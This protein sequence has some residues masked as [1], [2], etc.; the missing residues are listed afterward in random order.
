[1]W[2][3]H[4]QLRCL[5]YQFIWILNFLSKTFR[6]ALRVACSAIQ[7]TAHGLELRHHQQWYIVRFTALKTKHTDSAARW[8]RHERYTHIPFCRS[9]ECLLGSSAR[10]YT[11]VRASGNNLNFTTKVKSIS[12]KYKRAT[13]S[14]GAPHWP[15]AWSTHVGT[16]QWKLQFNERNKRMKAPT[17]AVTTRQN[18]RIK[19]NATKAK[20]ETKQ[21]KTKSRNISERE[22]K[23]HFI[24]P[25]KLCNT[26]YLLYHG[27]GRSLLRRHIWST[28]SAW[29]R[30]TISEFVS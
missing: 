28:G 23:V 8:T 11:G 18:Y 3:H 24:A 29:R 17:A 21:T 13:L 10:V 19:Q 1:M 20:A 27:M 5:L 26:T 15:Y 30:K 9:S 2:Y 22:F 12:P 16:A 4:N 25:I 14:N 7:W 6:R